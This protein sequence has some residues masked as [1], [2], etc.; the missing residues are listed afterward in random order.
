[1]TDDK[2]LESLSDLL[3]G[4]GW[5]W[6][7]EHV[8]REWGPAGLRYQQA[9]RDAAQSPS[10]IV[11]LQKVLHTQE[12]VLLLMKAPR[13]RLDRLKQAR[14]PAHPAALVSRRGPGL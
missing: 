6:F 11:E 4:Q 10:A 7:S 13:E 1:M 8:T 2:E 12:Q 3:H 5:A 14:Q 9:V